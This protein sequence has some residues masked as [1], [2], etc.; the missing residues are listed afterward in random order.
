MDS[1]V[2]RK[3]NEF[4]H[5]QRLALGVCVAAI[6]ADLV[7]LRYVISYEQRGIIGITALLLMFM[8]H[9]GDLGSLGLR[10]QPRQSW[11]V[12][13]RWSLVLGGLILLAVGLVFLLAKLAGVEMPIY[14]TPPTLALRM[15]FLMW[16]VSPVLEETLY[17][18]V[19]C[20]TLAPLIGEYK[21]IVL[22][23]IVF[24]GLHFLYGNPS[25]DNQIAGFILAWA[26]LKSE[27]IFVPLAMHMGGNVVALGSQVLAWHY[28]PVHSSF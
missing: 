17:R 7:S 6:V 8:I 28:W 11:R 19:F 21:T 24:G 23:G 26:F 16:F 12:W 3:L 5:S 13:I 10:A 15:A 18:I 2:G 9:D 22:N 4:P 14:R 25:P 1:S 20:S 27:C